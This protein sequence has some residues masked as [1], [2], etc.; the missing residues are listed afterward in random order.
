MLIEGKTFVVYA[1]SLG[2]SNMVTTLPTDEAMFN[3]EKVTTPTHALSL[4]LWDI[5]GKMEQR[6]RSYFMGTQGT[7]AKCF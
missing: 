3:V 6:R 4:Y 7:D 1:W 2:L 5:S